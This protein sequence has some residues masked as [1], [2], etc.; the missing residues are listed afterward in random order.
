MEQL[1]RKE[2]GLMINLLEI[3]KD[4]LW[5]IKIYLIIKNIIIK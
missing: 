1:N 3:K 2:I 5:K 4:K